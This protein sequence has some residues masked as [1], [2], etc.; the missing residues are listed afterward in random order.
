MDYSSLVARAREA[1]RNSYS[2]YSQF[3]VGAAVLTADGRVFTGCNIE[4]G[5]YGL[6]ICAERT[7]LYKA[8]SEG[9]HSFVALA[10]AS[11]EETYT[12]PCGACRQVIFELAGNIDVIL[13][14]KNGRS[15]VRKML[16]LLPHPFDG[17]NLKKAQRKRK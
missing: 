11:D 1:K 14:K 6:T 15:Q 16:D 12:P 5:S 10:I 13:T 7:A 2:P 9:G 8:V 17:K 4:N 3:R